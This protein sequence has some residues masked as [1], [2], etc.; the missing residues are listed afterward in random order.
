[1]LFKNLAVVTTRGI[2][3]CDLLVESG[4]IKAIGKIPG[5]GTDF[6]GSMAIPSVID[7]H[8]HCRDFDQRHKETVETATK[9]AV[10]GGITGIVDMPNTSPPVN[11]HD[12]FE[13]RRSLFA[14]ESYCD[15]GINFSVI[16]NLTFFNGYKF[17]KIFLADT[18]GHL[19]FEGNLEKLFSCRKPVAVHADIAGIRECVKLSR[20]YGTRLHVCHVSTKEEIIFLKKYKDERITVEVTPHHLLLDGTENVKPELG[21]DE[22]RSALWREMGDTIDI[23]A[24]D[25]APHTREEKIE[26]AYGISGVETLLPLTLDLALRN[27]LPFETLASLISESP[28]RLVGGTKGFGIG[29]DA[30]FTVVEEREWIVDPSVFHS[31][32]RISPFEGMHLK[33]AVNAVFIRGQMVYDGTEVRKIDAKEL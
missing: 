5:K 29:R 25:H 13:R 8:V 30:D 2:T 7:V 16:E 18:T 23:I 6:D 31:K 12:I 32:S 11:T 24:S 33:G 28:S 9:A 3:H 27:R 22:D 10:S 14:E 4:V 17:V 15:Y 21:T 19:L 1:M 20:K 26:G